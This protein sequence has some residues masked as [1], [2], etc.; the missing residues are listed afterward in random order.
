MGSMQTI[1]ASTLAAA[2]SVQGLSSFFNL[3]LYLSRPRR[4]RS[5]MLS[6][7]SFSSLFFYSVFRSFLFELLSRSA[8]P[9]LLFPCSILKLI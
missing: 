5:L 8:I 4:S 9:L 1:A 2:S 6:I 7:L 3:S